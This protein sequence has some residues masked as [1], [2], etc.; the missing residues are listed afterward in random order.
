M[1]CRKCGNKI[2]LRDMM[3]VKMNE[4]MSIKCKNCNDM[5]LI[6]YRQYLIASIVS[7]FVG[8]LVLLLFSI[9]QKKNGIEVQLLHFLILVVCAIYLFLKTY[10][11]IMFYFYK[12]NQ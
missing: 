12:N 1:N 10:K 6:Q 2:G 9:I 3:L 11:G 5:V 4:P 7:V 8:V